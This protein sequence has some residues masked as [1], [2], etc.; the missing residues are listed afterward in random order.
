MG[1]KGQADDDR[2]VKALVLGS[3]V[4]RVYF[5]DDPDECIE[6]RNEAMEMFNKAKG[7]LDWLGIMYLAE[8]CLDE[9]ADDLELA[10]AEGQ[11]V[12][13]SDF[14]VEI[15]PSRGLR[16]IFGAARPIRRRI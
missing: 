2:R 14:Q 12:R 1:Y 6:R 3:E 9:I 7:D 5:P 4:A 11:D 8:A 10:E 15:V 13:P 16:G